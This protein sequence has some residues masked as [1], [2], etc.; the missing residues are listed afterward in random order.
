MAAQHAEIERMPGK[1]ARFGAR[2]SAS[3]RVRTVG[4]KSLEDYLRMPASQYSTS[5]FKTRTVERLDSD[6]FQCTLNGIELWS[7]RLHPTLGFKIIVDEVKGGCDIKVTAARI[8]APPAVAQVLD[9]ASRSWS[10]SSV[11]SI[12]W[13]PSSLPKSRNLVSSAE[14]SVV[15]RCVAVPYA[16]PASGSQSEVVVSR[17]VT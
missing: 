1:I 9:T 4:S 2:S 7:F 5:V 16:P 15:T 12:S 8:A 17:Q 6:T 3:V 11:N 13:S 10:I 14:V